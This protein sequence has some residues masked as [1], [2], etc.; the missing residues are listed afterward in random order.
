MI[1][2]DGEGRH[3]RG[4]DESKSH[5][6]VR[7]SFFIIILCRQAA[8]WECQMSSRH[9][10]M[11]L[12]DWVSWCSWILFTVMR[13]KTLIME[14][15]SIYLTVLMLDISMVVAGFITGCGILDASFMVSFFFIFFR[16]S[17]SSSSPPSSLLILLSIHPPTLKLEFFLTL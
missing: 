9:W 13:A 3:W 14:S 12:T 6:H 7:L 17:S 2:K 4:P 15:I 5:L 10:L 16:V 11:K 8:S 1:N